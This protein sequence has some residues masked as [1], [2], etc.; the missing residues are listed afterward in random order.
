MNLNYLISKRLKTSFFMKPPM[1]ERKRRKLRRQHLNLV[2]ESITSKVV[3][4]RHNSLREKNTK[5]LKTSQ[6]KV[7]TKKQVHSI[8]IAND[9]QF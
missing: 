5:R 8:R 4:L 1:V 6:T 9:A 3:L 2:L 7:S